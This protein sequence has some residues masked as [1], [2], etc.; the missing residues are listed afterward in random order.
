MEVKNLIPC[1]FASVH[2]RRCYSHAL[3]MK[4]I[5]TYYHTSLVVGV[6]ML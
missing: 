5:L 2:D 1:N 3:K 6:Y 4:P